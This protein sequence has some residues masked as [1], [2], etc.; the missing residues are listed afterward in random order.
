MVT[1]VT[2]DTS[3]PGRKRSGKKTDA[4]EKPWMK[5]IGKLKHLHKRN[6]R[7]NKRIEDAFEKIDL[8]IWK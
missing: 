4:Q 6:E 1:K 3:Q 7:L 2:V 5:H 8:E